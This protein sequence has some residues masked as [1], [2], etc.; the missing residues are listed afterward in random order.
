[1]EARG[2]LETEEREPNGT[3]YSND[4]FVFLE[5]ADIIGNGGA[6]LN[7]VEENKHIRQRQEQ[8]VAQ[9]VSAEVLSGR[10]VISIFEEKHDCI[11]SDTREAREQDEIAARNTERLILGK[12]DEYVLAYIF[13]LNYEEI[14]GDELKNSGRQECEDQKF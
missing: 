2:N 12:E 7:E 10:E 4:L 5:A 8:Q 11:S 9:S 6:D 1:M 3:S 13:T 14:S